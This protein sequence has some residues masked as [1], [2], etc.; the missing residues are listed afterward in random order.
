MSSDAVRRQQ[1]QVATAFYTVAF[2]LLC[3]LTVL[4]LN[5]ASQRAREQDETVLWQSLA[6]RYLHAGDVETAWDAP[7][8]L[9]IAALSL[10]A[11]RVRGAVLTERPIDDLRTFDSTHF[12]MAADF[13]AELNCLSQ[14]I[15]YESR[16]EA[17]V[18][19]LAV[20]QVIMNRVRHSAYP[21][22]IC[23]VVYQGSERSTGC[24]FS[25]TCDGS[26]M[27]TPRGRAWRRAELI[28]Q[29][30]FMGFG[31]DVTRRATHYHTVAVD[32]HWSDTL[33]RTRRIGTHIFY[34]FPT[35]TERSA[36]VVAGRDA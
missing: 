1:E 4:A 35:R 29:H 33:V 13:T 5:A 22:T 21:D 34:R 10:E 12:S 2:V 19:Q 18:G 36:G 26:A 3:L 6:Q 25:F 7:R 24:Q 30:A 9:Q 8:T 16:S 17:F 27:R 15:Y 14:A 28:A 32:P 23:G 20:A 11:D 31:R